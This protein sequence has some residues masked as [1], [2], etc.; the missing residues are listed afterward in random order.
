MRTCASEK[1]MKNRFPFFVFLLVN[2]FYAELARG[3]DIPVLNLQK[4]ISVS[5]FVGI[6]NVIS[7][8]KLKNNK[9]TNHYALI[10]VATGIKSSIGINF[11][12]LA[13]DGGSVESNPRCCE[14]GSDYLFFLKKGQNGLYSSSNG[15]YGVYKIKSD[16]VEGWNV[17]DPTIQVPIEA[18]ELDIRKNLF[19]Q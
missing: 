11:I 16:Y 17:L 12:K 15:I 8:K 19:L 1:K 2:I 6:G 7:I 10:K 14:I 3:N 18:V 4:K 5:E 13:F 9:W